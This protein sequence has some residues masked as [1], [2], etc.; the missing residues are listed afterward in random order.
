MTE[1]M[2][3]HDADAEKGLLGCCLHD[4]SWIPET[5]K[6]WFYLEKHRELFVVLQSMANES[7]PVD[8]ATISQEAKQAGKLE[9]VGGV[10]YVSEVMDATPSAT[11]WTYFRD[12]LEAKRQLRDLEQLCHMTLARTATAN[13][14]AAE[15]VEEFEQA[16]LQIREDESKSKSWI[17]VSAEVEF[18]IEDA[19][20]NGK[21]R[22]LMSGFPDLDKLTNGFR[23]GQMI[24]I[25]G[26]PGMGKTSLA[27]SMAM[28]VAGQGNRAGLFSLEMSGK[29]LFHRAVCSRAGVDSRLASSGEIIECDINALVEARRGLCR[30][31]I[32][33]DDRAML[34]M[35]QIAAKARRWR[36]RG[37]LDLVVIDYLQLLRSGEKCG[38][39][40]NV[41]VT[42]I[43]NGI[44]RLA[45][46]LEC[47]VLVLS[48]FSRDMEREG[49][50]PRLS[51]LRDSGSIEQ[52]AD[53]VLSLHLKPDEEQDHPENKK[54]ELSIL[55]NRSGPTGIVDLIFEKQF[56]R[57]KSVSRRPL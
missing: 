30:M 55:K 7:K 40:R 27:M 57:F 17:E 3:T 9:K 6:S 45:R 54:V 2:P 39:N 14:N 4:P 43:S 34:A 24:V 21:P 53:L 44:K 12:I 13:G 42:L 35:P 19:Y 51:D 18:E 37:P 23:P 36:Q 33:I 15:L 5:K 16:A 41:E 10:A 8:L 47:P 49:R 38:S 46:D 28:S 1:R 25:A 31:R 56:T 50:K 32:E 52:D 26:R 48:Q 11:N 29:E 20:K 22:G